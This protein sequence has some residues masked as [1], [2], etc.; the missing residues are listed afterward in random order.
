MG[1]ANNRGD[2]AERREQ[3]IERHLEEAEVIIMLK[4]TDGRLE[5]SMLPR[6]EEP[7]Q[8]SPAVIFAAFINANFE[9]L[10]GQAM[11][12]Y[13][14][15]A[16]AERGELPMEGSGQI[17]EAPKRSVVDQAGQIAGDA[18]VL[19]GSDGKRLQ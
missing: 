1:E 11:S 8:D 16:A 13:M 14:S 19:L 3:A 10:A 9:Q 15:H 7:N 2:H 17:V 6:D 5:V 12:L 4:A 18:P